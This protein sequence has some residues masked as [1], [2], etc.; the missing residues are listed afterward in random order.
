MPFCGKG[1]CVGG[2]AL[3]GASADGATGNGERDST[4]AQDSSAA[5]TQLEAMKELIDEILRADQQAP[6]KE[7]HTG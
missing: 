5:T 3:G 2:E 1:R 6:C 7:W 4:R